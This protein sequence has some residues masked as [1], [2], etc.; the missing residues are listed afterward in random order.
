MADENLEVWRAHAG[1]GP[2]TVAF[3]W[4]CAVVDG[5]FRHALDF[6]SG[7]TRDDLAEI[8]PRLPQTDTWGVAASPGP[9]APGEE[10]VLL[11]PDVDE[12][13]A[14]DRLYTV[15]GLYVVDEP[16]PVP[17]SVAIRVR[18]TGSGPRVTAL[19]SRP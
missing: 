10:E 3:T 15:K 19:N 4:L 16:A 5:D 9:I 1:S 2:V 11:I 12:L 17:G 6:S 8:R 14:A 7:L 13:F 18:H